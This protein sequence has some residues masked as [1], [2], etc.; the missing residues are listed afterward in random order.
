MVGKKKVEPTRRPVKARGSLPAPRVAPRRIR[1][2][3]YKRRPVQIVA[4]IAL[5]IVGFL[6]FQQV[7]KSRAEAA[8]KRQERRAIRRFDSGIRLLETPISKA[9][10]EMSSTPEQ[11][12][13]GQIDANAFRA[14]TDEWLKT[15]RD[16]TKA[17][18]ERE[19]PP[20]LLDARAYLHHG[21]TLYIDGAKAFQTASIAGD[22]ALRDRL[23]TEATNMT[24]HASKVFGL[25]KRALI[26]EKRRVGLSDPEA[27]LLLDQ[28]IPLPAEE[29]PPPQPQPPPG[30]TTLPP[31]FPP[32]P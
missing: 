10:Q 20:A 2:P 32:Q 6:V 19:T 31:G 30:Q 25:G 16:A 23:L 12:K 7:R 26:K 14:K 3:I 11:F 1:L 4:I 28:P 8:E 13:T 21:A 15:F 17:L 29:A 5:L 18:A 24:D 22:A 9:R 27:Q